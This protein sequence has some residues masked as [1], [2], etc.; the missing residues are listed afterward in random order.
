MRRSRLGRRINLVEGKSMNG[1]QIDSIDDL[2]Q[3]RS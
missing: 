1:K 2:I 3:D